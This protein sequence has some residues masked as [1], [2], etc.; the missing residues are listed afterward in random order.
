MFIFLE[1]YW[2]ALSKV[3]LFQLVRHADY[4]LRKINCKNSTLSEIEDQLRNFIDLF[5]YVED[6]DLFQRFYS[7]KLANR[8]IHNTSVSIEL[9]EVAISGLKVNSWINMMNFSTMI[10]QI[11]LCITIW[12]VAEIF[13]IFLHNLLNILPRFY[14]WNLHIIYYAG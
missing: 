7:K 11:V 13:E 2:V 8:L 6:K 9:E 14:I 10:R 4:I 5:K 1:S 12:E 3:V